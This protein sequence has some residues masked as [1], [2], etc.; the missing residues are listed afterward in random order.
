MQLLDP[1]GSPLTPLTSKPADQKTFILVNGKQTQI[2]DLN[3]GDSVTF[4]VPQS[5][6]EVNALPTA[7]S[8]HWNVLAQ[9]PAAK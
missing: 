2:T 7:T 5:R 4:W 9:A 8:S 6:L 3:Q 1:A